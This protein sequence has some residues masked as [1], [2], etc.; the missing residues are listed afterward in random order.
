M[1]H[2]KTAIN[3]FLMRFADS[4]KTNDGAALAEFF[5][6]DGTLINPFGQRADGR[7]AV[8]AMYSDYF[9]GLLADTTTTITV[10]SIRPV[11]AD[12]ALV[13]A[14]EPI[15]GPDGQARLVVHLTA[16]LRRDGDDWRFVDVRPYTSAT[17]SG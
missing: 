3:E 10:E 7:P 13:D 11:G 5:T 15:H 9:A 6:E 8:A 17:P 12:H 1:G 2:D 14:D 16:L 4:W